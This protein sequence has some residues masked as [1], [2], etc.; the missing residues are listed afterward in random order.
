MGQIL[1]GLAHAHKAGI[2][3]RDLKPATC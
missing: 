3:H 2:I 1:K